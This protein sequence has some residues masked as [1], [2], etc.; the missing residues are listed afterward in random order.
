MT[1]LELRR[2]YNEYKMKLT[3]MAGF[4]SDFY[5]DRAIESGDYSFISGVLIDYLLEGHHGPDYLVQKYRE[6]GLNQKVE[7]IDFDVQEWYK[8]K[9]ALFSPDKQWKIKEGYDMTEDQLIETLVE[10]RKI[11]GAKNDE[12]EKE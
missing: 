2:K 8:I 12:G 9:D 6:C 3:K 10:R 7:D 4:L 1:D 5:I 11:E